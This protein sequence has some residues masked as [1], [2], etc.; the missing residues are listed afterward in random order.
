VLL[1]DAF[2]AA[3]A[4]ATREPAVVLTSDPDGLSRLLDGYS[5]V[6]VEST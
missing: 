5:T 3:C 2:V 6:V 1:L 4:V